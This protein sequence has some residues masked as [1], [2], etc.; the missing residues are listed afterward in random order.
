V[1][2]AGEAPVADRG[3]VG[4]ISDFRCSTCWP[5]GRCTGTS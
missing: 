4:A 3:P 2:E 5:S 1:A